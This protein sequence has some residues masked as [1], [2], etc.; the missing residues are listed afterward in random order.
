MKSAYLTGAHLNYFVAKADGLRAII[1][2]HAIPTP[3]PATNMIC[4]LSTG[5]SNAPDFDAGPYAPSTDWSQGGPIIERE[6][7]YLE[8]DEDGYWVAHT[9]MS[10]TYQG[11]TPLIA[12]MRAYVASR[13][14]DEVTF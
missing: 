14:G 8:W 12:C 7:F 1:E 11:E 2:R 13:F 10:K 6:R 4:W 3:D 5:E 9:P